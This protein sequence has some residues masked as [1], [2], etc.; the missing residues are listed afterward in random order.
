M[1]KL[2]VLIKISIIFYLGLINPVS[3]KS[4][5]KIATIKSWEAY[6]T[7]ID[8]N[9][10]CYILSNP[11]KT[12]SKFKISKRGKSGV[13]VTNYKNGSMHEISVVAGFMFKKQSKVF[14]NIDGKK[15]EMIAVVEDRAWSE[16]TKIDRNLVKQMK[17]GKELIV[18]GF[19][20]RGNLIKDTYSLSG[21]TKALAIIDKNCS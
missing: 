6:T 15:T 11:K 2:S 8:K 20:E 21:F 10:A 4:V 1:K 13:F 18:S 9:K 5:K 12:D 3:S 19:S 14:F 16:S 7:K 17:K